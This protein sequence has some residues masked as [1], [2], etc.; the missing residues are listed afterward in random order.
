MFNR[1][2]TSDAV[3][4]QRIV[5]LMAQQGCDTSLIRDTLGE[6]YA[7][8]GKRRY[9]IPVTA[10][11]RL[12]DHAG[13]TL[14]DPL[15]GARLG[16]EVT[17]PQM[18][19]I[20]RILI[21]SAT[22]RTA[23]KTMMAFRR[24][25]SDIFQFELHER[26]HLVEIHY[27]IHPAV[28]HYS[29][30][31]TDYLAAIFMVM[32]NIV[33]DQPDVLLSFQHGD[34]GRAHDYRSLYQ[35]DVTFDQPVN[36]IV[37]PRFYLDARAGWSCEELHEQVI[38]EARAEMLALAGK[39]NLPDQ[40]AQYL[41]D[42]L[43]DG[44]P[45]IQDAAEY[46]GLRPRTL[47]ARLTDEGHSFRSILNSVRESQAKHLLSQHRHTHD[48]IAHRLGYQD[49]RSFYAA[50]KRWTGQTPHEFLQSSIDPVT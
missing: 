15:L 21:T 2:P 48:T 47:Q 28:E 41:Q 8:L 17:A 33:I 22:L 7:H 50:F 29:H 14:R 49:T 24:L 43:A 1:T 10:M 46:L 19:Y 23:I 27:R 44:E 34:Q 13:H 16:F 39:Y 20:A 42:T 12:Y 30:H 6:L 38:Q 11:A 25:V 31:Q 26:E 3:Y 18:G 45:G 4:A 35:V 37:F 36:R 5:E 32:M 40:V 9:R